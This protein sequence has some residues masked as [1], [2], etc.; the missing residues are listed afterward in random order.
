[1]TPHR[2]TAAALLTLSKC[3][4][5]KASTAVHI[6]TADRLSHTPPIQNLNIP[7]TWNATGRD[8][9]AND[10]HHTGDISE[11][12]D[13]MTPD[14]V[15]WPAADVARYRAEGYWTDDTFAGFLTTRLDEFGD[16]L[17]V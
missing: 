1:W 8:T 5:R 6:R 2:P 12:S 15:A 16:R 10:H 3:Y 4:G 7:W 14:V 17:A 11:R 13:R 9:C